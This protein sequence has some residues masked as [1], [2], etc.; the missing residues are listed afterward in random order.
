LRRGLG[1]TAKLVVLST[2]GSKAESHWHCARYVRSGKVNAAFGVEAY[3]PPRHELVIKS[4]RFRSALATQAAYDPSSV[5]TRAST[6]RLTATVRGCKVRDPDPCLFVWRMIPIGPQ[7][8]C[9]PLSAVKPHS[10]GAASGALLRRP[11]CDA[12]C[13][14]VPGVRVARL[15]G[16][17]AKARSDL[18]SGQGA[19]TSMGVLALR[20]GARSGELRQARAPTCIPFVVDGKKKKS[21][22]TI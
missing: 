14:H 6:A 1:C 18:R 19:R 12:P 15:A 7:R 21:K 2:I 8:F 16:F 9:D 20:L 4:D 13:V 3:H 17:D 22:S 11:G 5:C 10:H